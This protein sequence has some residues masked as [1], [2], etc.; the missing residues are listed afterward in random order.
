MGCGLLEGAWEEDHNK[1]K[2]MLY[3]IE[4]VIES[5]LQVL[6]RIIQNSNIDMFDLQTC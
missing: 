4:P 3:I 1:N 2:K 5:L 6:T